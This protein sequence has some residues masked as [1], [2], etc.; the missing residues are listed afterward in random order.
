MKRMQYLMVC[1]SIF[2]FFSACADEE[3]EQVAQPHQQLIVLFSPGGLGDM[4][5]NDQVL[6]GLQTVKKEREDV[7][8]LY[9]SPS[10]LEEAEK[11]FSDWLKMSAGNMPSLFVFAGSDYEDMAAR[12]LNNDA[13]DRTNKDILLFE[14]AN[15]QHLPLHS[16]QISMYGAS[17]LAGITAAATSARSALVVLGNG[18]DLPIVYAAHGFA[19]GFSDGGKQT[20]ETVSLAD[21][22]T[23]FAAAEEAYRNM[24][25]WTQRYSFVYPVAGG[26]NNGVFRYIREYPEGLYTAGMDVDQA[27]LC[28][29][30]VGSVVKHID[31]L[32]ED[33]L[34]EWIDTSVM[35]ESAIYGLESGYID[36]VLSPNDEEA[37]DEKVKNSRVTAINKEKN[38]VENL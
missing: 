36:W 13:L 19:E 33:Y 14:S 31:L 12:W 27:P 30:I 9:Y 37:F 28:T 11:I 6:R 32:I 34:T 38:Y 10:S 1:L 7:E 21:D 17:Y 4:G 35:P 18:T 29:Q 16:F 20:V 23:G 26:S 24:S 2:L 25:D 5:Y 8:M 3:Q 22:W 15:T